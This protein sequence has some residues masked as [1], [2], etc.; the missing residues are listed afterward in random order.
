MTLEEAITKAEAVMLELL[1]L[2]CLTR[3]GRPEEFM[4]VW[5]K[6]VKACREAQAEVVDFLK[7]RQHWVE[8]SR[9]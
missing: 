9:L 6:D 4:K 2:E 1:R 3:I 5:D 8:K 7:E